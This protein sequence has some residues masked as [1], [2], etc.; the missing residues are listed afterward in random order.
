VIAPIAAARTTLGLGRAST[1]KATSANPATSACTRR[2]TARR[3]NGHR[4][5]VIA[6]ATFAPDTAVR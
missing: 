5:P 2:S 1:T 6:I 4:T 3:R